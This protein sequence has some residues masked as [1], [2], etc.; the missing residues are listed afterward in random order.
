[1]SL[2]H[3]R[4]D[5][6]LSSYG[7]SSPD[8]PRSRQQTQ[9]IKYFAAGALLTLFAISHAISSAPEESIAIK[10]EY[11]G[12]EE[13]FLETWLH[14][15]KSAVD[16]V[17][18]PVDVTEDEWFHT[19]KP[20]LAPNFTLTSAW[21]KTESPSAMNAPRQIPEVYESEFNMGGKIQNIGQMYFD[22][23]YL[24]KTALTGRWDINLVVS[25]M[26]KA[27]KREPMKYGSDGLKI[28]DGAI[29][30]KTYIEGRRGIVI[31]SEDPWVEAILLHYGA[32]K[33]LTVEFGKIISEHPNIDTMVPKEFT[34]AFLN[35]R[36]EQFD[37]G[38]SFS[39]LE[40]DGLG[41]YGDVVNPIGDLQSM[42]KMLSV[43]KPGGL[44]F[45]AVP[46]ADGTD[47]LVWN[48]HRIYGKH[49]LEKIFAGWKLIDVIGRGSPKPQKFVQHL[50]VL[51]NSNGCS[52]N[53]P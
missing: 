31:G 20:D 39:S 7:E 50:W 18:E 44:M 5:D 21:L 40:H 15:R 19:I 11:I 35:G 36:I 9:Q 43:I 37:F 13:G 24:G 4:Q 49:R 26:E 42:A 46:T 33:L 25:K 8:R 47:A 45:F 27:S 17:F 10:N 3:H 22:E 23:A 2:R 16:C 14:I 48:A 12:Q 29:K 32:G 6:P 1:M 30:Y 38:M 28:H 52:V 53:P 34:D 51:Q 41:R